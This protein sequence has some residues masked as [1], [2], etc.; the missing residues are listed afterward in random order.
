MIGQ[1][2]LDIEALYSERGQFYDRLPP[3]QMTTDE[4]LRDLAT[5]LG[6]LQGRAQVAVLQL[7]LGDP[8]GALRTLQDALASPPASTGQ[9]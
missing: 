2:I 4:R 7:Q 6:D 5:Q 8:A 3:R 9:E 1:P